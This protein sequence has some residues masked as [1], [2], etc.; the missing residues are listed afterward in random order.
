MTR[1]IVVVPGIGGHTSQFSAPLDLLK[2]SPGWVTETQILPYDHNRG[3]FSRK[4]AAQIAN[5]LAILIEG[6]W[7]ENGSFDE[8]VLIGHSMG[9]LLVRQAYLTG[10]GSSSNHM[11]AKPWAN[12]VSRMGCSLELIAV[13]NFQSGKS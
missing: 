8:I 11:Q 1:L 6:A 10:L 7:L 2:A 5:D 12:K 9:A 3:L 4:R 13:S